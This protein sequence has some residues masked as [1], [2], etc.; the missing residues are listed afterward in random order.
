MS[1]NTIVSIII[2]Y[3]KKKKFI[4]RTLQSVYNQSFKNYEIIF[5]YDD[6]DTNDIKYVKPLIKKFKK[7]KFIKNK[8]NYGVAKSRNIAIKFCRGK[9]ISFLDADDI[10]MKNKLETQIKF[11]NSYKPDICYTPYGIIDDEEKLIGKRKVSKKITYNT[12][13]KTCEIGLSTVMVSGRIK[14]EIVFAKLKTQEDF[15]L[16]LKLLKKGYKFKRCNQVLSNWRITKNSLSSNY[17]QKILDAF[18]L[19]YKIEN[20]NFTYSLF[21]VLVLAYNKLKK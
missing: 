15:A 20:K 8:K 14:K 1:K 4:K 13:I 21:S 2:T 7:F 5:V 6:E 3:F 18:T 16:W 10:W 11:M 9:F 12:L 17:I 19:F